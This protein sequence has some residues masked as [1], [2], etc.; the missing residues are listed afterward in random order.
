VGV[1]TAEEHL[2]AG[3]RAE[4]AV[5]ELLDSL[6]EGLAF[7]VEGL[8]EDLRTGDSTAILDHMHEE[9]VD[10]GVG[11]LLGDALVLLDL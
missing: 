1:L 9:G 10:M 8:L 3:L 11:D 4:E 6:L 2:A 5:G 7:E